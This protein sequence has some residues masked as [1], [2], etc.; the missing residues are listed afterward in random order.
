MIRTF[1]LDAEHAR[2]RMIAIWRIVNEYLLAGK[3][4]R[5]RIDEKQATRTLEQNDKF[6]AI[7]SDIAKQKMW[8]GQWI[9]TE[10]WKRL[11]MD[12]WARAENRIQVRVVPSLDG[13]SIV[14]L[15]IQTRN[16]RVADMADLIAFAEAYAIDNEVTLNDS[17]RETA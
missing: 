4:V 12:S 5:I 15:G 6:H 1:L 2:D 14:N 8:A 11:L 10:G 3:D 13:Q 9:D 17:R 16:M 7:C